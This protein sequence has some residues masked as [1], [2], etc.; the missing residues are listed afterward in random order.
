MI[1]IDL[2]GV[3]LV[4]NA[5]NVINKK[6]MKLLNLLVT[7]ALV[8]LA[9]STFLLAMPSKVPN[10][11]GGFNFTKRSL[12]QK[13]VSYQKVEFYYANNLATDVNA[14]VMPAC[15]L[16]QASDKPDCAVPKHL[17][18]TLVGYRA[19]QP[20]NS[21]YLSPSIRIYP[22]AEFRKVLAISPYLQTFDTEVRSLQKLLG[23]KPASWQGKIPYLPYVDATQSFHAHLKYIKFK[24]G[25]GVGSVV[26]YD[27]ENSL[28]QDRQ[29]AYTF[30]GITNNGR[31]YISATFPIAAPSLNFPKDGSITLHEGY[32][33]PSSVSLSYQ[34]EKKYQ[35]YLKRMRNKLE[36]MPAEKYAPN[37]ELLEE[38]VGSLNTV[39]LSF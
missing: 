10:S 24:G 25:Q 3:L 36:K 11:V 4:Y 2:S 39:N 1:V 27:T 19:P 33:L 28:V 12:I 20:E 32:H 29:L 37:L 14:T 13:L 15:V 7:S 38:L 21:F 30:Q 22:I 35:V 16:R 34:Q 31:Y 5:Y 6:T 18:F 8:V 17:A 26:R 9:A 23:K